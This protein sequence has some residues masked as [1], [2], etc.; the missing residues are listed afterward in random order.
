LAGHGKPKTPEDL[1]EHACVNFESLPSGPVWAFDPRG[2]KPKAAIPIHPRLS[3]NTAEAAID[4]AIAGVGLTHVLSYQIAGAVEDGKLQLVLRDYE[5]EPI[6]VSLMYAGQ[7]QMPLKTRSFLDF[8]SVRLKAR[9][10]G[11]K[12]RLRAGMAKAK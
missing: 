6:P 5:P 7:G 1:A 11:D 8:V 2:N 10:T 3:V 4:A 9:L 12:D